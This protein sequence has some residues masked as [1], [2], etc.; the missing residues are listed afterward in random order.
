MH[1]DTHR[2]TGREVVLTSYFTS[3]PDPQRATKTDA[4]RAEADSLDYIYPW[5]ISMRQANLNGI[6]F[7]DSLSDSFIDAYST[8]RIEFRKVS[9]GPYSLNDERFFVYR[10]FLK[11]N[12]FTK[13]LMTDA[14]D[15]FVKR[16]PFPLFSN[17][18]IL[19]V[20][21]DD[22][23]WPTIRSSSW[24]RTKSATMARE[25]GGQIALT[26][27]FLDMPLMNAG[28]IGGHYA[29]LNIFL[30]AMCEVLKSINT[31]SNHNMMAMHYVIHRLK[32]PTSVGFPLT[33]C[34]KAFEINSKACIVH[35]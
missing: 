24:A 19:Y 28:V 15:L 5:Y 6:V 33:S 9:L 17:P 30:D 31:I 32:L 29:L 8:P 20:G 22:P 34:F 18:N 13:V 26:E 1:V 12:S 27:A 4:M 14:S 16:D 3:K 2:R 23:R 35:K 25:S 7:H 21:S 10:D 11:S